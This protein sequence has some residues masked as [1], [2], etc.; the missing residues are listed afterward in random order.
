L[1][2]F[3]PLADFSLGFFGLP[4]KNVATRLNF[5]RLSRI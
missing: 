2:D 3:Q 5:H 4:Q 1:I